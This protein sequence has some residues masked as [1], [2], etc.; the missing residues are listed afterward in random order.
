MPNTLSV[1]PVHLIWGT[2]SAGTDHYEIW[3]REHAGG[4]HKVGESG[5]NS[6]DDM[7]IAADTAYFYQVCASPAPATPCTSAFS[8]QDLATTV[9]FRDISADPRVR[10]VDLTQLLTAVNA[11]RSASTGSDGTPVTWAGILQSSPAP[12]LNGLVYGEH[13]MALRAQMEAALQLLGFSP[14]TYA[15]PNL[16]SAPRVIIK[17]IHITELRDRIQ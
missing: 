5:L 15:D 14:H 4:L 6:Y 8:N 13:I 3:R 1:Q 9:A 17:A 16:P 11:V 10:L 7:S 2:S 12:A